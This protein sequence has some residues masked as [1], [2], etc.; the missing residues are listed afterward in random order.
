VNAY[1][2]GQLCALFE[3]KA[4]CF[5]V[6]AGIDSFD[7]WGVELGK[8]LAVGIEAALTQGEIPADFDS[9]TA[10]LLAA[11]RTMPGR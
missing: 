3:H 6:L 8:T 1:R 4:F 5:G 9:S 7:Q 10:G 11:L 2:L